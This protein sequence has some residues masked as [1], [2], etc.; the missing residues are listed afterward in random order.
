[1]KRFL[2]SLLFAILLGSVFLRAQEKTEPAP[3][4]QPETAATP[5]PAEE[6][7]TVTDD[8]NVDVDFDA[9]KGTMHVRRRHHRNHDPDVQIRS[10][11]NVAKG[12]TVHDLVVIAGKLVIDGTVD[13]NV[14]AVATD[15][16]INGKINGTLVV[17]PG[18]AHF[19]PNAEVMDEAI[20][21]GQTFKDKGAKFH[22]E[23]HPVA[24]PDLVPIITGAKDFLFEGVLY[25][26]PLPPNVR[27]VWVVH[28]AMLLGLAGLTLLFPS[29]VKIGAA[30]IADRPVVS[31]LSGFLTLILFLPV[32]V[33][34]IATVV[35]IVAVPFAFAGFALA[36]LFGKASVMEF[37]GLQIGRNLRV[38]MLES[39]LVA[40]LIGAVILGLFYMVPIVGVMVWLA[41]TVLGIGAI[42]VA[43]ATALNSRPTTPT[44]VGP[45]PT[46]G[47]PPLVPIDPAISTSA[48][49]LATTTLTSAPA[50]QYQRVGF[51]KRTFASLLDWFILA[52]PVILSHGLLL[53]M[54]VAYFVAM[55]TWKGTT[56]GGICLG[57][58]VVRTDGTPVD[59][60]VSL[61]RS[62]AS[63]FS[64][65][66]LFLGFFWA[67]WD[68]DK[69]SW[70]DKIAGTVV[71][72]VPKGMSLL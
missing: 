60:A 11:V 46:P 40:L 17:V 6:V 24:I 28:G 2:T 25:M 3:P 14:V 69:Q 71:V 27:W 30:A 32:L 16:T 18:P 5:E 33:L 38:A 59:F 53:L 34:L 57:L 56:I 66:V 51:W 62:L 22:G 58:K 64:F 7:K 9:D 45:S 13:G 1:M 65:V 43:T 19:G 31:M 68:K 15:T 52:I 26:R 8:S 50:L 72:Q 44:P 37:I 42:M 41:A 55:W 23:F 35:G 67:G 48:P 29:P 36:A 12:E 21:V 54:A 20:V 61:V 63:I 39:P 10:N 49:P 47:V 70:H 4:A